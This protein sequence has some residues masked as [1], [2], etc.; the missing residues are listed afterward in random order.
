MTAGAPAAGRTKAAPAAH[1][2]TSRLLQ[3]MLLG[4]GCNIRGPSYRPQK[5]EPLLQG[6]PGMDPQA[7]ETA[8]WPLLRHTN[9]TRY[10]QYGR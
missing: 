7:K 2:A 10:S 5:V 1:H 8:I 4:P 6:H 9:S 3:S